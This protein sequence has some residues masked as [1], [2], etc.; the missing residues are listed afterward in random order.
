MI[1]EP[2]HIYEFDGKHYNSK[3]TAEQLLNQWKTKEKATEKIREA[4]K[5][6][7]NDRELM[8]GCR[9]IEQYINELSN[10]K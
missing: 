3:E 7:A 9:E 4:Y 5:P 8:K 6:V 10:G 2:M 1:K